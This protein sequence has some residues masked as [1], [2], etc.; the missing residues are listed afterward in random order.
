MPC[1][2]CGKAP[3][4]QRGHTPR[5]FCNAS[6]RNK[7]WQKKRAEKLRQEGPLRG[8]QDERDR[9]VRWHLEEAMRVLAGE[10][11]QT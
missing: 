11:H 9:E 4:E 1:L 2:W 10:E 7:A 6:C 5:L 3:L 8:V